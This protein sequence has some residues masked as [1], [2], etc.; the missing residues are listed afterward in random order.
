MQHYESLW[1]K[2][3]QHFSNFVIEESPQENLKIGYTTKGNMKITHLFI[4][5]YSE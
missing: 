2:Y 4:N 3:Q 5:F 1:L